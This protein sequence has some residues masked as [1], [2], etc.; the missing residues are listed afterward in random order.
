[1][2]LSLR[3]K[4]LLGFGLLII[5]LLIAVGLGYYSINE[6]NKASHILSQLHNN[7]TSILQREIDHL[8]WQ[9]QLSFSIATGEQFKGETDPTKCNLGKWLANEGQK[10]EEEEVKSLLSQLV[11]PHQKLHQS[12]TTVNQLLSQGKKEEALSEYVQTTI[13]ALNQVRGV[14]EQIVQY[15]EKASLQGVSAIVANIGRV[16]NT[17]LL[18]GLIAIIGGLISAILLYRSILAPVRSLARGCEAVERGDLRQEIKINSKD[19]MGQVAH[20]FNSMIQKLRD[21]VSQ[22]L[23]VSSTL[24]SSSEELSSSI[25]E[26]SKATEEIAKTISQVAQGSTEQS[27]ELEA[28]NQ[29]T[30]KISQITHQLSEA[31]QRNLNLIAEMKKGLEK[32]QLSLSEIEQAMKITSTEGENSEKEARKGQELLSLL[33]QNIK[34]ISQVTQ[35]VAQSISTLEVRSQEISKIVDLITGIAEETNLLA[36]NAAIEAARAGEAGRGFAVVANEVRK[37]AEESAQAAQQ[38]SKLIGEVKNDT[39]MAVERM[40]RAED[41]VQEGVKESE[42]VAKNFQ[43]ILITIQ[44]VI[45]SVNNLNL[46]FTEAKNSQKVTEKSAEEVAALSED[47]AQM[48]QEIDNRV[49]AVSKAMN[50]V[51]LVSEENAASSQEVSASTEEQSASL[52]ELTSASQSLAQLAQ[53]LK[54]L[55]ATFQV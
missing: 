43:N 3:G 7:R 10:I 30:Q 23:R 40:E 37:L 38:I 54:E 12:A 2:S 29:E 17:L 33:A 1:M 46:V 18:V 36:L 9:E 4:L 24:A 55:V 52:E 35:E 20:S 50:S 25:E 16:Q 34:V 28:I 22:V 27:T 19:E 32:N 41:R 15:Y 14:L 5:L 44:K 11:E 26:I 6:A 13:P 31:T 39:Q 53:E 47:N 48:I 45:Q 49:Q 8:L 21:I 51:A 42:E